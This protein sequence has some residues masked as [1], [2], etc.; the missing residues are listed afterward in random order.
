MGCGHNATGAW[1][2]CCTKR[3]SEKGV[4]WGYGPGAG[5]PASAD[6]GC[7]PADAEC[8][9]VFAYRIRPLSRCSAGRGIGS[10]MDAIGAH[11]A[12]VGAPASSV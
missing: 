2:Q 12:P 11:R 7:T 5:V 1:T 10:T 4:S 8:C 9:Y 6:S 3:L